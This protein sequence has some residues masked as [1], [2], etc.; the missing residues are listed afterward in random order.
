MET[1]FLDRF[2]AKKF[3]DIVNLDLN[4][5]LKSVTYFE[6]FP[7]LINLKSL[8]LSNN[9]FEQVPPIECLKSLEELYVRNVKIT[10]LGSE[11]TKNYIT[12]VKNLENLKHYVSIGS[13]FDSTTINDYIICYL[14]K[15][16]TINFKKISPEER[17]KSVSNIKAI[18]EKQILTNSPSNK[19]KAIPLT[20]SS[21]TIDKK[22]PNINPLSSQQAVIKNPPKQ[23]IIVSGA[24]VAPSPSPKN[25][26]KSNPPPNLKLKNTPTNLTTT[27]APPKKVDF[28]IDNNN[29]SSNNNSNNNNLIQAIKLLINNISSIEE[30]KLIEEE[31]KK[32]EKMF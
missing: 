8:I 4:N 32:R 11:G 25:T 28:R 18:R 6:F 16:E 30:L 12:K 13:K 1:E 29:N 23:Q 10:Q 2:K 20:S 14:K 31:V 27:V 17:D 7:K 24:K 15:L 9:S 26:L 19:P 22:R 21:P 5:N 3:E